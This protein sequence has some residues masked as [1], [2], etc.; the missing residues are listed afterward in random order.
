[1]AHSHHF[2]EDGSPHHY[3]ILTGMHPEEWYRLAD[4]L[5][6]LGLKFKLFGF[7]NKEPHVFISEALANHLRTEHYLSLEGPFR[8][9]D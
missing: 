1:M 5:S 7:S 9:V 6:H 3:Y 2:T 4:E 8:R